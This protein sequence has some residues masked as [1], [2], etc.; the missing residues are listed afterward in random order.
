VRQAAQ[1]C[2]NFSEAGILVHAYLMYGFPT[3]TAQET[4]DSLEMVRQ[5]FQ[6]GL[7]QSAF[8][9]RFTV[10]V[11][12]DVGRDPAKYKIRISKHPEGSFARND[13]VHEDPAG[14]DH[15]VFAPGLNKAV[16]NFMHGIG[17]EFAMRDW[18]TFPVPA[19]SVKRNF[20]LQAMHERPGLDQE[21]MRS[22]VVWLGNLPEYKEQ[23]APP[24]KKSRQG[25]GG[26]QF[27][28]RAEEFFVNADS[29]MA[30]WLQKCLEQALPGNREQMSL[31]AW[32]LSYEQKIFPS[33]FETLLRSAEWRSLRQNGLLLL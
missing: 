31:E 27:R 1:V 6:E 2:R 19:V 12:S 5:F 25:K 16:Y 20:V 32:K 26:L 29:A 30:D 10:T 4:V 11:H 18:F 17:I 9:H 24:G 15:E 23:H 28:T 33:P 7:I 3:E 22:R 8:W 14:C 13:L 21:R